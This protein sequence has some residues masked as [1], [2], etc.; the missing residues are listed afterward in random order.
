M[1]TGLGS[2]LLLFVVAVPAFG[3]DVPLASLPAAAGHRGARRGLPGRARARGRLARAHQRAGDAAR[4]AHVPADLVHLRRLVPARRRPGLG[5]DRPPTSSRS[6]TSSTRSRAASWRARRTRASPGATSASSPPGASP[7]SSWR[8]G[9]CGGRRPRTRAP[10]ARLRRDDCA[11]APSELAEDVQPDR[12][13]RLLGLDVELGQLAREQQHAHRDQ[14]DAGD[15]GDDQVAV[16]QPAERRRG[17]REGDGGEQER[18]GEAE[19]VEEQQ[20]PALGDRVGDRR[21]GQDRAERRPDARRPGDRERGPGQQRAARAGARDQRLRA[22]LAVE[23]G[24]RTASA[25]RTR[26]AR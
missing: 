8:P 21:G 20:D 9:A 15:G 13:Q 6:S 12:V 10:R 3:V 2:V 1:L 4:P 24:P 18:D 5:H 11:M 7:G 16:A 19:R 25:G 23:A 14:H 26:R 22:P 17:A